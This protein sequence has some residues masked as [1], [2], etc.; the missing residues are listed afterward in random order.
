MRAALLLC[1]Q[2]RTMEFCYPSQKKHLLDVYKPDVFIVSDEQ[3]ERLTELY[4]PVAIDVRPQEEMFNLALDV[5]KNF[6]SVMAVNDLSIAW[7]VSKAAEMKTQHERANGFV[8]SV[9]ILTRFDV[10]FKS[11]Q[12]IKAEENTFHVPLVGGYWNTPPDNPGIHW[13]GYSAHLCWST[14]EIMD[15][16]A[17]IYFDEKDYLTLAVNSGVPFGWA[18]EHVLKYFCDVNNINVSFA[19]IQMMLIRGTNK[20]PLAFDN[21]KIANYPDYQ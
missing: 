5:R 15:D 6:P 9:V 3:E 10:K 18:P 12:Q 8:Y 7:K 17:N 21:R 1:G 2:P 4:N 16:I 20:N 19:D 11:I 13:G 14:S